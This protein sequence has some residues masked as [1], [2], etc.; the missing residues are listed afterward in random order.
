MTEH[1]SAL[2]AGLAPFRLEVYLGEWEFAARPH[3]F[4][5]EPPAGGCVCFPRYRGDDGV[6]A[7]CRDAVEQAGVLLL[8]ASIYTS[9]LRSVPAD[10]FRIG[11]G[12]R[13]ADDALNAFDAFLRS[14]SDAATP[15]RL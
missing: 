1:A 3:L 12:R 7:M 5:F 10:R 9:E 2:T 8:P 14:R 13:G 4:D 6:E 11:V 15:G